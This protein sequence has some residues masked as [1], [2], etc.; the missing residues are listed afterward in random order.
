VSGT[1]RW[2]IVLAVAYLLFY[3]GGSYSFHYT[4][5]CVRSHQEEQPV[6]QNG[7]T[8]TVTV[9]DWYAANAKRW[10]F[11]DPARAV[12]TTWIGGWV[13]A[14]VVGGIAA[15]IGG[16][17]WRDRRR[18]RRE[19]DHLALLEAHYRPLDDY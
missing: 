12:F 11:G 18:S 16:Y 13:D 5:T 9:C 2:G 8:E 3:S 1:Q 17:V 10:S 7:D 14:A 15:A 4:H 6:G 19:R